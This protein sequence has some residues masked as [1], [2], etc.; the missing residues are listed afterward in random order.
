MS[1]MTDLKR[2]LKEDKAI[3]SAARSVLLAQIT[4]VRQGLSGQRIGEELAEKIGDP[5]LEKLEKIKMPAKVIA[6]TVAG[7]ASVVAVALAWKPLTEL[8]STT[9]EEE[10]SETGDDA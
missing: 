2:Q 6:A 9:V 5:T 8:F 4:Q 1:L 10:A 3:R 7:A